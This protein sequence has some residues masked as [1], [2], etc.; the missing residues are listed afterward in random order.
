MLKSSDRLRGYRAIWKILRDR[1]SIIV[2]RYVCHYISM[3][4]DSRPM[5]I[6][7]NVFSIVIQKALKLLDPEGVEDRKRRRLKRRSYFSKV[8]D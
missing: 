2:P 5:A 7:G 4:C 8:N 6:F 3:I 1:Y